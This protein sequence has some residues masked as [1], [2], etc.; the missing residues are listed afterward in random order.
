MKMLLEGVPG[1]CSGWDKQGQ[2]RQSPALLGCI[3]CGSGRGLKISGQSAGLKREQ[4]LC[5]P[6]TGLCDTKRESRGR[7]AVRLQPREQ[8][9]E[10]AARK[11]AQLVLRRPW[12]RLCLQGALWRLER[13]PGRG[14]WGWRPVVGRVLFR[15]GPCRPAAFDEERALSSPF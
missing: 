14:Q 12:G 6:R 8:R 11:E 7:Q 10:W 9:R 3:A 15:A 13:A 1:G 5:G 2:D 4:L